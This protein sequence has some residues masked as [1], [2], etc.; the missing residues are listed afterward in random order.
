MS[1]F[2]KVK[3][4]LGEHSTK[5]EELA[6]QGIDKTAQAAK[7]RTGG[8]YDEHIDTASAKAREMADRIDGQTGTPQTP[9]QSD[10]YGAE[11][12]SDTSPVADRPDPY[13]VTDDDTST[14]SGQ[15][16]PYRN[17][18]DDGTPPGTPPASG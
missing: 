12:A 14:A 1:I 7:E 4:L 2:D 6:K 15:T 9:G 8:K 10:A 18:D 13:G 5:A 17:P 3:S 11:G 16:G